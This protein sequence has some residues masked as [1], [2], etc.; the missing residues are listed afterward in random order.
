VSDG[1]PSN[2][3]SGL[4]WV[5]GGAAAVS[6]ATG[7]AAYWRY[8]GSERY[9][10]QGIEQ[11]Q[12][13]GPDL[14]VEGCIDAVVGWHHDCDIQGANAAVCQQA[15]GITMFHCLSGADRTA[16]CEPYDV[17]QDD[18]KWVLSKCED[19]GMRCVNKR[20]CACADAYR[21]VDSFCRTGGEAVQL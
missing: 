11:M 4:K 10:A 5:L 6:V 7:V 12:A 9:V 18:G 13:R 1:A 17:P 16:E 21:A 19:R 15:V 2:S 3:G 14:D 20:E 8:A